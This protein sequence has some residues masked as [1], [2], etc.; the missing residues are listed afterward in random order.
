MSRAV[1]VA[2]VILLTLGPMVQ[3]QEHVIVDPKDLKWQDVPS[4]PPGAKMAI[5][6]GPLD[7]AAPFIA[8][9][10]LP[11][12]YKIPAHWHPAIEHITVLSGTFNLGVGDKLDAAKT[13]VIPAGG[14]GINAGQDA[15]LCL[16]KRRN[17][18]AAPWG[19]SVGHYLRRSCGG[20][21]EEITSG[22]RS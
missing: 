20:S 8:R 2:V 22:L 13:H 10:K 7:Q 9:F 4:L 19:R 6:E 17:G 5:I 12:D 16:D 3:A 15:P 21:S 14:V 1:M 11:A 18:A